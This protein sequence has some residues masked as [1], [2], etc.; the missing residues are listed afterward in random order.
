MDARSTGGMRSP[1]PNSRPLE[2]AAL[3][4][5][6]SLLFFLL[7]LLLLAAGVLAAPHLG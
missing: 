1:R 4:P 3:H 6:Y 5:E 7:S 2:K